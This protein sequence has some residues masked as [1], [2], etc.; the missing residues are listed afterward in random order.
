[1][2]NALEASGIMLLNPCLHIHAQHWH[3]EAK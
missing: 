2:G 1:V 3:C